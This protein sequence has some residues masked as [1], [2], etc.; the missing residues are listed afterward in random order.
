M[1]SYIMQLPS[2]NVRFS[3]CHLHNNHPRQPTVATNL[4]T[5]CFWEL[6]QLYQQIKHCAAYILLTHAT[7]YAHFVIKSCRKLSIRAANATN[8]TFHN[9]YATFNQ[10]LGLVIL[11]TTLNG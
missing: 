1:Y 9:F 10:K 11:T 8:R 4:V 3:H 2:D 5:F 7:A 6:F